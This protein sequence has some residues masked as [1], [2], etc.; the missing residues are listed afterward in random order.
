[1]SDELWRESAIGLAK[2]IRN[3]VVASREVIESHIKRIETHARACT[4]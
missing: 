2:M 1:M 4:D 3:K